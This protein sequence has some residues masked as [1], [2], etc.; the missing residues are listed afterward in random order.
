MKICFLDKTSFK[1]NSKDINSPILRGAETALINIS[2]TLNK[3][4]YEITIINNCP[5]NEV[6]DNIRWININNLSQKLTFDISISNN[7]CNF[8]DL[9]D[10]KK[11]FYFH[12]AYKNLKNFCE[13]NNLFLT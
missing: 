10:S 6:I 13:K 11:K 7:D 1:Y 3:L 8:F 2:T 9:I 4:G 12:I 5:K